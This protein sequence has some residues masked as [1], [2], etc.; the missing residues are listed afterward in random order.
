MNILIS[1]SF[2]ISKPLNVNMSEQIVNI[3]AIGS[4][5]N[6]GKDKTENRKV[7]E[8]PKK[9]KHLFKVGDLVKITKLTGDKHGFDNV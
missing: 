2:Y 6:N 9:K 8:I 7:V 1:K 3:E 5:R 4:V